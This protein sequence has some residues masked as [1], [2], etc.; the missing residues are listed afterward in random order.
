MG[1]GAWR[2]SGRL[3]LTHPEIRSLTDQGETVNPRTKYLF[4]LL[5]LGGALLFAPPARAFDLIR[6]SLPEL[7]QE[8]A[9]LFIGR[10]EAVT[11]HWNDDHSLILTASRFRVTRVLKGAPGETVTLDE[12]GGVVG[13]RAMDAADAPHYAVG[14]EVLLCVHRTEL[15]RWVTFG[16]GQGRFE[17]VRDGHGRPWVQSSFYRQELAAMAPGAGIRGHAPLAAFAGHLLASMKREGGR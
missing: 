11:C 5:G 16:G 6:R 2:K 7:A 13:D 14:E 15:G 10:C 12:L 9:L 4:L 1:P 17:I 3:H 8:S